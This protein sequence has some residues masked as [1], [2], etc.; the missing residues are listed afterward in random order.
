MLKNEVKTLEIESCE[1]HIRG[2]LLWS[3]YYG[4]EVENMKKPAGGPCS[5]K[6]AEY[7][8]NFPTKTR[9]WFMSVKGTWK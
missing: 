4:K 2:S 5:M 8:S 6:I 1:W 9:K 7:R 3:N